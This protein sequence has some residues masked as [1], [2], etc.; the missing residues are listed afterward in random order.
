MRLVEFKNYFQNQLSE[1]YPDT[2]IQ[3]FLSIV[4]EEYLA[5]Q[6]IDLVTRPE[7]EIASDVLLKLNEVV[8]RLKQEEPI[9]HI[10][11]QTEFFGLPFYV[12]ENVLIP[13]PETEELVEFIIQEVSKFQSRKVAE[14]T[15]SVISN[16]THSVIS[17][18]VEKSLSFLD[19]GTGSGCIPISLKK[20]LSSVEI[21]AIDVSEGA[22]EVAKKNAKL[23]KVAIHFI[24]KD[25]LNSSHLDKKYDVIVSNPPYVRELEKA[26]MQNNVLE[27]E[28]ELALFV[29]DNDP[30]IFYRK[31]AE[32]AKD[33]LKENGMLFFEINQ[34]LGQEMIELLESL[35][36]TNIELRKDLFG[37]D[38][39]ISASL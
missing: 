10:I 25:I 16:K 2:E 37:K 20:H 15:H 38:R 7:F 13:R 24:Q 36:F 27:H 12:N 29:T 17:S 35:G 8:E 30:L 14:S 19:I 3:S 6:R 23:N 32:L 1:I 5:L 22:L 31:I 11:G 9:Q 18:E 26:E 21:S 34:Y 4:L 39:M 33:H 28:P